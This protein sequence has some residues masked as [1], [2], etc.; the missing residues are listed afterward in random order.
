MRPSK[1]RVCILLASFGALA[2]CSSPEKEVEKEVA[3]APILT[4]HE[5]TQKICDAI[6]HSNLPEKKRNSLS[7]KVRQFRVDRERLHEERSK[8]YSNLLMNAGKPDYPLT[9]TRA[10]I[11]LIRKNENQYVQLKLDLLNDLSVL[12]QDKIDED[13]RAHL[14]RLMDSKPYSR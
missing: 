12:I 3:Q 5:M 13:T 7:N 14:Y 10:N 1:I 8:M 11:A 2:A 6:D 9:K 4:E